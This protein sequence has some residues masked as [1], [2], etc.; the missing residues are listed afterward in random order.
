MYKGNLSVANSIAKADSKTPTQRVAK[1]RLAGRAFGRLECAKVEIK[2]K[3]LCLREIYDD[4]GFIQPR[5]HCFARFFTIP[6]SLNLVFERQRY[7][8][9]GRFSR[10][11]NRTL[12]SKQF[13][14]VYRV[15][16]LAHHI[17]RL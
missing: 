5:T 15:A 4:S 13:I 17:K 9:R 3:G 12:Y 2:I 11:F 10:Y 16:P 7:Y 14:F 1:P 6:Q 8:G